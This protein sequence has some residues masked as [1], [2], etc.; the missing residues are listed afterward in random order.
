MAAAQFLSPAGPRP[1]CRQNPHGLALP[2][3]GVGH[4]A[5]ARRSSASSSSTNVSCVFVPLAAVCCQTS[6]M[7]ASSRS[8]R[9][10]SSSSTGTRAAAGLPYSLITICARP[11]RTRL[12]SCPS[13]LRACTSGY[14]SSSILQTVGICGCANSALALPFGLRRGHGRTPRFGAPRPRFEIDGNEVTAAIMGRPTAN[15][16]LRKRRQ[17][18]LVTLGRGPVVETEAEQARAAQVCHRHLPP[19]DKLPRTPPTPPR[20]RTPTLHATTAPTV[21]DDITICIDIS[22]R[23]LFERPH[24]RL[25]RALLR[26]LEMGIQA[27][28]ASAPQRH[29]SV[30]RP[31]GPGARV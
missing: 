22:A 28:C 3:G 10:S 5:A 27:T 16:L 24:P 7:S 11:C 25:K 23:A 30:L 14:V 6:A 18:A 12:T 4:Q 1:R 9:S 15:A 19:T 20:R 2:A 13:P 31:H 26:R 29:T 17:V 8:R 21:T